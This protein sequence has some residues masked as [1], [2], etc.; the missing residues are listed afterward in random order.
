MGFS[1]NEHGLIVGLQ[2]SVPAGLA[3]Q[4]C[5]VQRPSIKIGLLVRSE[6]GIVS[7]C[8][9]GWP[10]CSRKKNYRGQNVLQG[11]AF[12]KISKHPHVKM[13]TKTKVDL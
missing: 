11:K 5:N 3:R 7:S 4:H 8:G 9:L 10:A 1:P 6:L 12:F 13:E 2:Q